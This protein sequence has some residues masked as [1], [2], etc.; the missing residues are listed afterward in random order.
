MTCL[1]LH[2]G[3]LQIFNVEHGACA[4][5]TMPPAGYCHR[6][7]IDCGHNATTR[8]YPGEHLRLMG[9]DKLQLL[10]VTNYD[11]DHVSGFR[12]LLE[13]GVSIDRI[14]RNPAITPATIAHLKTE[15]GMGLGIDSLVSVLTYVPQVDVVGGQIPL[16]N[17][18][19]MEW[20]WNPYPYFDDE[21]NLSLVLVLDVYGFKFMFPGDMEKAGFR[22][23]L[24]TNAR[25]R[26]IVSEIHVLVAA[27]HGRDNGICEEMF[28]TW[29]CRPKLVVISDDYKQYSTQETTNYYGSKAMGI[30]GFRHDQGLRKVLTTRRDGELMFSFQNGYCLVS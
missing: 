28:D 21:N 3:A 2:D 13:Q 8:W 1:P 14:L 19:C 12:N 29:G 23:L 15:D 11:E 24:N 6:I 18:V 4:L 9:I 25:F 10:V 30:A 16:P 5:L 17:G 26:T 22:N 27:H 7:L 20:F